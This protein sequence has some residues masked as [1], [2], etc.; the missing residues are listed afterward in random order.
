M[1]LVSYSSHTRFHIHLVTLWP[2]KKCLLL[3]NSSRL[4][5]AYVFIFPENTP[6]PP[7]LS[8][9]SRTLYQALS[10][11]SSH[12]HLHAYVLFVSSYTLSSVE[13]FMSIGAG[14][15][16]ENLTETIFYHA[17]RKERFAVSARG[18]H[19]ACATET[20]QRKCEIGLH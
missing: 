13:C 10:D 16:I 4:L 15:E 5:L 8:S 14:Y 9:I 18:G 20:A 11:T 19:V 7:F 6:V 1:Q 2:R 17:Q 12:M 3:L